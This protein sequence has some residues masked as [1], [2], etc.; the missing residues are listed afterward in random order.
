MTT[1]QIC[2]TWGSVFDKGAC[3]SQPWVTCASQSCCTRPRNV[4]SLKNPCARTHVQPQRKKEKGWK[5]GKSRVGEVD[6]QEEEGG[7]LIC[8][9]GIMLYADGAGIVSRSPGRLQEMMTV[10]V[11]A[12]SV[13][14]LTVS[15]GQDGGHVPAYKER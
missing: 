2:S 4:S 15:G 11:T 5:R 14:G 6:E 7:G 3:P 13:F 10:I 8:C 9:S 12:C 1:A